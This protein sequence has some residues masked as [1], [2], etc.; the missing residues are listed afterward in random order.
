MKKFIILIISLFI[1]FGCSGNTSE[2]KPKYA[3]EEHKQPGVVE[4]QRAHVIGV[5]R[6]DFIIQRFDYEGKT[7]LLYKDCIIQVR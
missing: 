2:Y 4:I 5:S 1:I 6:G 3:I 7:Y